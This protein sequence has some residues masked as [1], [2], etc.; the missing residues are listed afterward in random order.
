M[1]A[2]VQ[3]SYGS[4]EQLELADVA[5]PVPGK[6]EVLVRVAAAGVDRGTW[7]VLTGLPLVARLGLGLRRPKYPIPGRDV[8][9]VAVAVGPEV[10]SI[11]MGD[12]VIGTADGSFAE[13]AVVPERRLARKP[14]GLSLVEAATLPVSGLT[15]L[16]AVADLA[17]VRAG[18]H[19]LVT[20]AS[21]G[22]GS[23]AVQL[24]AARGAHVTAVC[25]GGKADLVRSLGATDVVDYTLEDIDRDGARYDTIIDIAGNRP[26]SQLR[27][28]LAPHGTLVVVGG[29]DG[30]RWLGG[31]HRQLGVVLLSPFTRQRLTAL[32][33]K[34]KG[35]DMARPAT[36]VEQGQVR[37]AV[38]RTFP[39]ADAAAA[40][41]YLHSGAARGKI[42]VTA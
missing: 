20:G 4:T 42:A 18:Q 19:V 8:A 14:A 2:V 39:L 22:V 40:I 38:D 30:G 3:R 34:E 35:E 33:S 31:L 26:L 28:V 17:Q 13:L 24:A 6:G 21:G 12:E 23:Y 11:A 29:E 9:G 36:L 27:R 15:A 37:P 1:K 5:D 16:Q 41:D 32:V 7:H 10:R 25:S